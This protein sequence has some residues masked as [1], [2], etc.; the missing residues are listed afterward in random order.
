V[1]GV[2]GDTHGNPK[3]LPK[4]RGCL[5]DTHWGYGGL[6]VPLKSLRN[7]HSFFIDAKLN[8]RWHITFLVVGLDLLHWSALPLDESAIGRNV[9]PLAGQCQLG[10]GTA[11]LAPELSCQPSRRVPGLPQPSP[12]LPSAQWGQANTSS[13]VTW[14][15]RM[16]GLLD[17]RAQ[18]DGTGGRCG[19]ILPSGFA[20][21]RT[22][23]AWRSPGGAC[24]AW[25]PWP[26]LPL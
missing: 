14:T 24:S 18:S 16:K 26:L 25:P 15:R 6:D 13:W 22:A 19:R 1:A 11:K 17:W 5:R 4:A 21:L 20:W 8:L 2:P 10:P 9:F 3:G 23:A 7:F 12:L